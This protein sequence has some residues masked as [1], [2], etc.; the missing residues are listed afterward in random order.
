MSSLA[1]ASPALSDVSYV[2]PIRGPVEVDTQLA[3]YVAWLSERVDVVIADGSTPAVFDS[4]TRLWGPGVRHLAVTSR[5]L[6]GKVAGVVD[7]V[8][9]ATCERVVVADDDVRYDNAALREIAALLDHHDV[10][11][12][13]NYFSPLSWHA[14]WDSARSLVN[15]AW[16]QDYPGTVGIRRSSFVEAGGYCGGVLFE[17][18]ELLRTMA[19]HGHRLHDAPDLLVR[20]VPPATRHFA[21]QR[22]RQAYDSFAQPGRLV[23]ELCV[24]P[25]IGVVLGR[26]RPW[27][28]AAAYVAA[29]AA[30]AV[31]VA[32]RGRRRGQARRFFPRT[33][34]W[35]APVWVAERS[36]CSW[37]AMVTRLRGGVVYGGARLATAAHSI[38]QLDTTSCVGRGCGCRTPLT[39]EHRQD[40]RGEA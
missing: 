2:L 5:C 19:A 24:L 30:V 22:V 25:L 27:R 16:G 23:A 40:Q 10:V 12:P 15:R 6:N 37:V 1:A 33:G 32:E 7:G 26:V 3:A 13:Q 4:H 14:R 21:R 35:W 20:R 8:L 18:L 34:S 28:S 38:R 11:R 9:A 36:V 39:S 31:T 17:N 29:G